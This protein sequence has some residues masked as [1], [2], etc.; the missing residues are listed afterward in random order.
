MNADNARNT[1]TGCTHQGSRRAV[2]PKRRTTGKLIPASAMPA[3]LPEQPSR[4]KSPLLDRGDCDRG[5]TGLSTKK[6]G[7]DSKGRGH[8]SGSRDPRALRYRLVR[9]RFEKAIRLV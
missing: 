1:T 7:A 5:A 4:M 9:K 2:S 6:P 8:S 3:L